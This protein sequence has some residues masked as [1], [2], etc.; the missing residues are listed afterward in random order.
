MKNKK[1]LPYLLC[2]IAAGAANGLFGAGGGMILV[3]LLICLTDLK[4]TEIFPA[5]VCI[6]AP[7]CIVSLCATLKSS[8]FS[9]AEALPYLLGSAIGGIIAGKYGNHISTKLLHRL[10]GI[11]ILWGGLRYLC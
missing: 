8:D 9:F 3:P 6:I 11:F 5:S 1:A 4:E 2:G 10:L 7:I